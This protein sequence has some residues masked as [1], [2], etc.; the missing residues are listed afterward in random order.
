MNRVTF[1]HLL[2]PICRK[3]KLLRLQPYT[4][5]IQEDDPKNILERDPAPIHTNIRPTG[6]PISIPQRSPMQNPEAT[7]ALT[8]IRKMKY[9]IRSTTKAIRAKA[10][11]AATGM[12]RSKNSILCV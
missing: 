8:K 12:K 2:H 10:I 6:M 5:G 4:N 3:L 9:I 7:S 1:F 11:G